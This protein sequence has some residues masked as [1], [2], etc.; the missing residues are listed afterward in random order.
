MKLNINGKNY[1]TSAEPSDMLVWVIRDELGLT[2]T[3]FGCGIGFCGSCTVHVNGQPT[4]SCITP[5][6]A[7]QNAKIRTIE[8]LKTAEDLHPV[9]EAFLEHQVLQCGWCMSGQMMQAAALIDANPRITDQ[10]L[11]DGMAGNA[12]RC[13]SYVRIREAVLDAARKARG[14]RS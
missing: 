8:G 14:E 3:K 13:G 11:L 9:Q 5:V 12:C 2:G 4:R 10:E 6:Q 7:V 1:E